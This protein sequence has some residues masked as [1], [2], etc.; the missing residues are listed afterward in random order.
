MGIIW[1]HNTHTPFT[2]ETQ[3]CNVHEYESIKTI[4][5]YDLL[6]KYISIQ[7]WSTISE[8]YADLLTMDDDTLEAHLGSVWMCYP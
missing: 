5:N 3:V 6:I 1:K 4:K 8:E 2:R 7:E